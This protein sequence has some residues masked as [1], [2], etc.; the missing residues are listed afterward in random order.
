[1]K[2]I[3][4]NSVS[5]W[6]F[7]LSKFG[8]EQQALGSAISSQ[9][10]G[11]R[12]NQQTDW[13]DQLQRLRSHIIQSD[14]KGLPRYGVLSILAR[15]VPFHLYDHPA[16]IELCD[17]AFTDG[18]H[19]FVN[20]DFLKEILSED[21]ATP[22]GED[23]HS[24]ILIL[25]HELSHI[26]FRHHGR[27]PA[28][29][30]PMLWA[31]ACDITINSRL[32][33]AYPQLNPGPIFDNAW[34]TSIDEIEKYL[35]QS[36]EHIL[37]ELWEDPVQSAR[38]FVTTL[39]ESLG[40][41]GDGR[42][43]QD[44]RGD[45][46][47]VQNHMIRAEDLAKTLDDNGL[48]HIRETLKMP[49]PNDKAAFQNLSAVSDLYLTGDFDKAK[50]IRQIH[51]A[52]NAMAGNHLEEAW[53]E[54]IE[55]ESNGL[56]EWKNLLRDLL[57]GE[58]MRY[59]HCDELPND[60]YYVD[61]EQMGLDASLYIGSLAPATPGGVVVCVVDTSQSVSV[62][63]LETFVSEL[64]N[65]IEH[66]CVRENQ[67]YFVSADSS[68]RSDI[69][70]YSSQQIATSPEKIALKGRGGTDLTRVI[71][72]IVSWTQEQQEFA[73]SDL[74]AI[75]YFTDLLDRPPTRER[76]PRDLPRLLFLSPPSHMAKTFRKQVEEFA[77][78]AEIRDGTVID[79]CQN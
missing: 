17:T 22:A 19:I 58:G 8:S 20:T 32:I 11:A 21:A 40:E 66:E 6:N 44:K 38:E 52:G 48:Q 59:D 26:L 42:D 37:H 14:E 51:P 63:L 29:A 50:E 2:S 1:M 35:G 55:N 7:N 15:R 4:P 41:N 27:L 46:Q 71:N 25:L 54:W 76:L 10:V 3:R 64:N 31:I 36:E 28:N 5:G 24:M 39:Q 16:L 45:N 70:T 67:V 53:A 18:I 33:E 9:S 61:A 65:M 49:D 77:Q 73:S 30:P 60:I 78:V 13:N 56:L 68:I 75:V 69:E 43:V 79:L 74:E 72:E 34:G 12:L 47:D 57:L 23:R 62:E